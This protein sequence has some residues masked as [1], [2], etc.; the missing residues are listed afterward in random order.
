MSS[1]TLALA[2]GA[3]TAMFSVADEAL[4]RTLPW[5]GSDRIMYSNLPFEQM[6]LSG[7][8]LIANEYD[9]ESLRQIFSAVGAYSV[10]SVNLDRADRPI[11]LQAAGV[12]PQFLDVFGLK[13]YVGRFFLS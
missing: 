13:P 4:L 7:D 3:A 5:P 8:N 11:R 1:L 9:P 10:G 6:S 2:V 12:T